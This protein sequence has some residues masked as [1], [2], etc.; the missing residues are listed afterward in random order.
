MT[1]TPMECDEC[2]ADLTPEEEFVV[3]SDMICDAV[4]EADPLLEFTLLAEAA[5]RFLASAPAEH[6]KKVRRRLIEAV[7]MVTRHYVVAA[8]DA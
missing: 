7:D 5:G 2:G 1:H 4:D 6:R 8:C 3:R